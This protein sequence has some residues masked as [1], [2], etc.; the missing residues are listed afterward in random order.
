MLNS[1]FDRPTIG[2]ILNIRLAQDEE[3]DIYVWLPN[4][5][6][7]HTV[8]SFYHLNQ[9][10]RFHTSKAHALSVTLARITIGISLQIA[11]TTVLF[12]GSHLGTCGT[13]RIKTS[14]GLNWLTS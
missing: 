13:Y 1:L 9:N 8:K 14:L 2:N 10:S 11:Y 5:S 12:V 6:G 4:T 3:D 7:S